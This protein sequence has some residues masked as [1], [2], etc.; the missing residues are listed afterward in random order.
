MDELEAEYNNYWETKRFYEELDRSVLFL[1]I[2]LMLFCL[3]T[4]MGSKNARFLFES[5][6]PLGIGNSRTLPLLLVNCN[7]RVASPDVFCSLPWFLILA[8][9]NLVVSRFSFISKR[10]CL[11]E[12]QS[13]SCI[14]IWFPFLLN[15]TLCQNFG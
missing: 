14:S 6:S 13:E 8:R 1:F 10:N 5:L 15:L 12:S 3:K 11:N 9:I 2:P 4:L 7:E